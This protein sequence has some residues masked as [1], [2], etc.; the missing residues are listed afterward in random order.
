[1]ETKERTVAQQRQSESERGPRG[2]ADM[3]KDAAEAV[4]EKVSAAAQDAADAA[5]SKASEVADDL[6]EKA[7]DKAIDAADAGRENAAAALE[8]GAKRVSDM[9]GDGIASAATDY[10][11]DG[12]RDAAKYLRNN[13]AEEIWDDLERYV[14]RYPGRSMIAAIAAGVIVGKILR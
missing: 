9:G 7:Q 6:R 1:M 4:Q 13:E 14:K 3:A 5:K 10:A 12:M 2:A 8:G 11:A